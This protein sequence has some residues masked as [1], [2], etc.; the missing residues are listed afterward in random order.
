LVRRAV[1]AAEM[2]HVRLHPGG[3]EGRWQV[4]CEVRNPKVLLDIGLGALHAP[5]LL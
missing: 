3:Y 2:R 5:T 4:A 1:P